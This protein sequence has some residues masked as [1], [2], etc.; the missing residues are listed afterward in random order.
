MKNLFRLFVLV[1]ATA[2]FSLTIGCGDKDEQYRPT[3]ERKPR[4][5]RTEG[6]GGNSKSFLPSQ[7]PRAG[8]GDEDI[9]GTGK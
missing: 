7:D 8:G 2:G 5:P 4:T 6:R 9:F 3:E 1:L